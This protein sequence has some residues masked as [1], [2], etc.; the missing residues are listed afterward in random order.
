[1]IFYSNKILSNVDCCFH[2][3]I[4]T[5]ILPAIILNIFSFH[6]LS[7]KAAWANWAAKGLHKQLWGTK[8]GGRQFS[9]L[10]REASIYIYNYGRFLHGFLHCKVQIAMSSI[11]WIVFWSERSFSIFSAFIFVARRSYIIFCLPKTSNS[12]EIYS[13][14]QFEDDDDE[15]SEKSLWKQINLSKGWT[16][17]DDFLWVFTKLGFILAYF[18]VCDRTN[19]LMKENKWVKKEIH[20]SNLISISFYSKLLNDFFFPPGILPIWIFG[21]QCFMSQYWEY[22]SMKKLNTLK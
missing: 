2:I 13:K 4:D 7:I 8:H 19:F 3:Y 11:F 12:F 1:M 5:F 22:F 9:K 15:E 20:C 10:L 6:I 16:T 14:V 21:S 17:T 18:Y